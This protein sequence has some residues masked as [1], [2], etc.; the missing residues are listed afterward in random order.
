MVNLSVHLSRLRTTFTRNTVIHTPEA[1]GAK[2][3]A[4]GRTA[5]HLLH[6]YLHRSA[7]ALFKKVAISV[8][9]IDPTDLPPMCR[10]SATNFYS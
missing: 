10:S 8:D 5:D 6:L 1:Q 9:V 4:G 3:P 7:C 2:P